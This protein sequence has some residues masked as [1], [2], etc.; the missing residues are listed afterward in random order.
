MNCLKGKKIIFSYNNFIYYVLFSCPEFDT[1]QYEPI[2]LD[3]AHP[4]Y[5]CVSACLSTIITGN[6]TQAGKF[7][8]LFVKLRTGSDKH[9]YDRSGKVILSK[10]I[11]DVEFI[12]TT[13]LRLFARRFRINIFVYYDSGYDEQ[14]YYLSLTGTHKG[15]IRGGIFLKFQLVEGTPH[16]LLIYRCD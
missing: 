11:E 8:I 7:E 10:G 1:S 6:R 16:C 13:D 5:N 9:L 4:K 2:A 14:P 12:N 15:L 3:V